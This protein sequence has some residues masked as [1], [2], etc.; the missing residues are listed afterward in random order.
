[1][2][3]LPSE[4]L[5]RFAQLINAPTPSEVTLFGS[6]ILVR[7]LQLLNAQCSILTTLFGILIVIR[8]VQPLNAP[9]PIVVIPLG[10]T[11]LVTPVNCPLKTELR[12]FPTFVT[13]NPP[14]L[15][16]I[17]TVLLV[18]EYALIVASPFVPE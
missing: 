8:L 16:G 5:V 2:I 3:L 11:T 10:S 7:L 18:P 17:V 6:V 13:G 14:K 12:P 9:S 15:V 4:I 1:V